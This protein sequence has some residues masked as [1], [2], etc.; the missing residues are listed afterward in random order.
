MGARFYRASQHL[1]IIGI[2]GNH[3]RHL[4]GHQI[5]DM[6]ES[7][8]FRVWS[9]GSKRLNKLKERGGVLASIQY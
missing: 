5:V 7:L 4:L 3:T 6:S 8:G 1:V 9:D 2:L